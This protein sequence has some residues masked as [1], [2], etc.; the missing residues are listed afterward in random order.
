MQS[1][2]WICLHCG[3]YLSHTSK[4]ILFGVTGS[5]K[6]EVGRA[7]GSCQVTL[8]RASQ[9][10]DWVVRWLSLCDC[11][12]ISCTLSVGGF[13]RSSMEG[14]GVSYEKTLKNP[15][16][17]P[18]PREISL[19]L[20]IISIDCFFPHDL[21]IH[22][23]MRRPSSLVSKLHSRMFHSD[24]KLFFHHNYKGLREQPFTKLFSRRYLL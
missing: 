21:N 20:I 19:S 2:L 15:T 3:K 4:G 11:C 8:F 6:L 24:S 16:S 12:I 22:S 1:K 17:R 13:E 10:R 14:R 18:R 7:R 5:I 23:E 9:M